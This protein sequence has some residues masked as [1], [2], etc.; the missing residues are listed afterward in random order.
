MGLKCGNCGEVSEKWQ[1]LRLMDSAPL[2]GGRGSA[3]MVQKCKLCSRENSIDILSQTI[4]P[5]NA[6]DS[7]KFKT[8][9]EFECRGLEP[10]DFQPQAG[11][12][13]EGAESGTPFN[14]INLLE[15]AMGYRQRKFCL[16]NLNTGTETSLISGLE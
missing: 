4:K 7:E 11:F 6:E 1:Y 8:I 15:K 14:D 9:V 2:K 16:L 3:T 5:Y 13:A 10:V 12:A